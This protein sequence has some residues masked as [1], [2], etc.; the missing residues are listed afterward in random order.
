MLWLK[1]CRNIRVEQALQ[2]AVA[3]AINGQLPAIDGVP[4]R[5]GHTRLF[6]RA[7]SIRCVSVDGDLGVRFAGANVRRRI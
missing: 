4:R 7:P 2:I 6:R 1:I 3:Q 5:G